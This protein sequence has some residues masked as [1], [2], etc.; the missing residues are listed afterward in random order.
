MSYVAT[1]QLSLNQITYYHR[2][3][4]LHWPMLY[5]MTC[6]SR[7]PAYLTISSIFLTVIF[8]YFESHGRLA[9]H[10][11]HFKLLYS[12]YTVAEKIGQ[13]ITMVFEDIGLVQ[14]LKMELIQVNQQWFRSH[15]AIHQWCAVYSL[16]RPVHMKLRISSNSL[17]C[18]TL[19]WSKKTVMY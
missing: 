6:F 7:K 1:V 12:L 19:G 17:I 13:A 3:T 14:Q 9:K 18:S 4:S 2:L 16:Q 8:S 5:G 15:S 10:G 11:I